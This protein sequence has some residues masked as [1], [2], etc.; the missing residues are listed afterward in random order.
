[1]SNWGSVVFNAQRNCYAV[2]G[3]WQGKRHYFSHYHSDLGPRTC[4]TEDEAK[5]LQM[6]ISSEIANST[7]NP[8]RYQKQ[9]PLHIKK[10]APR[11][12]AEIEPNI[13]YSTLKAYRAGVKYII[14]G[15]GDI[16]LPDLNHSHIRKWLN[17]I[18]L[19]IKTKKNYHGVLATMLKD[20][21]RSGLISQVPEM[22]IFIGGNAIPRKKPEWIPPDAQQSILQQIPQGDRYIFEF[23]MITGV[24]PSEGRALQ[25][26]DLYQDRGYIAIRHTF[27]PVKGG[28]ALKEVKQKVERNI[29]YYAGLKELI[30]RMPANLS[31]FVFVNPRTGKPY[32]KNINRDI[33]NPACREAGIRISLNAACRHSFGSRLAM[34]GVGMET[35]RDL[36]GHSDTNVTRKFYANPSLDAMKKIVDN[37]EG[38][39]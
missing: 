23:L 21:K 12:L 38:I 27:A 24:R 3:V 11:W 16:F 28:E 32:T 39:R 31:P 33:W 26:C 15:L 17:S 7:F 36:L 1:M 14:D 37:V 13:S 34:Q 4:E 8:L 29:P 10:Y 5:I 2:R 19:N 6:V 18:D 22:V 9:K 25:K 20:A 30:K 35:I